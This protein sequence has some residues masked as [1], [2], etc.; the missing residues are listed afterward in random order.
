MV[1]AS[2]TIS[3]TIRLRQR[4]RMMIRSQMRRLRSKMMNFPALASTSTVRSNE[5]SKSTGHPIW[6]IK[7]LQALLSSMTR[8]VGH[9]A[10][11]TCTTQATRTPPSIR[12]M[13]RQ[14]SLAA[15]QIAGQG[16][17]TICTIRHW[18]RSE[19]QQPLL[20]SWITHHQ[21]CYNRISL[22]TTKLWQRSNSCCCRANSS[23]LSCMKDHRW[24]PNPTI[25]PIIII[26]TTP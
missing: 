7:W 22:Q 10:Q 3:S 23:Q 19:Q 21:G 8:I 26:R 2:S 17:S 9:R 15:A 20:R 16:R 25:I 11:T 12:L 1:A 6:T 14:L 13:L 5:I 18:P 24:P 4:S